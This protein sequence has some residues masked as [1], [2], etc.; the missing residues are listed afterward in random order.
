MLLRSLPLLGLRRVVSRHQ[1]SSTRPPIIDISAFSSRHDRTSHTAQQAVLDEVQRACEGAGFMVITGHDVNPATRK[2]MFDMADSFFA[3]DLETKLAL[4]KHSL[5]PAYRGY[6]PL[7]GEN[8]GKVFGGDLEALPDPVEKFC[9]GNPRLPSLQAKYPQW[10]ASTESQAY[11]ANVWPD[12]EIMPGFRQAAEVYYTE[13]ESL[14]HTMLEIF[15]RALELP[16]GFFQDGFSKGG[17]T[18]L[19]CLHYPPRPAQQSRLHA[20]TD[21][22]LLTVL[23]QDATGGLEVEVEGQ[24]VGVPIVP[25]SFVINIGDLM[26]FWLNQRWHSTRHR[27]RHVQSSDAHVGRYSFPLF[28]T[29]DADTVVECHEKFLR[30]GEEPQYSPIT[31]G[32]FN[33]VRMKDSY[34]LK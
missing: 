31:A 1:S 16:P 14:A 11:I 26:M 32:E 20:H 7:R 34:L 23:M 5:N 27:V 24:W 6:I 10:F 19:R 4:N 30:D 25:D 3:L 15:A 22:T 17:E 33:L 2:A 28:F 12:E 9:V 21:G 18:L 29:P 13:V 8:V